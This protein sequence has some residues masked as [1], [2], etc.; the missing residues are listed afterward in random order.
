MPQEQSCNQLYLG[1]FSTDCLVGYSTVPDPHNYRDIVEVFSPV[2]STLGIFPAV[3]GFVH[4]VYG[5]LNL[6]ALREVSLGL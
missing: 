4:P 3:P 5:S 6:V 1:T 2:F